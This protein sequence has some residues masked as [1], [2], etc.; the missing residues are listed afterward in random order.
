MIED[1]LTRCSFE[2]EARI[3]RYSKVLANPEVI[4][5]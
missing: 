2:A 1:E 4:P 5:R 3:V